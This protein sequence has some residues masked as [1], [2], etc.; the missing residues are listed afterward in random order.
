MQAIQSILKPTERNVWT[1]TNTIL[2]LIWYGSGFAFRYTRPP[3]LEHQQLSIQGSIEEIVFS[4]MGSGQFP[5]KIFFFNQYVEVIQIKFSNGNVDNL[6][7]L[8]LSYIYIGFL[9]DQVV[10]NIGYL[11]AYLHTPQIFEFRSKSSIFVL[12]ITSKFNFQILI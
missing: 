1:K 4:N 5:K 6:N 2:M 7:I 3:H 10:T 12:I 11:F 8:F 9:H